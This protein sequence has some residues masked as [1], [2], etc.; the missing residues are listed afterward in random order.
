MTHIGYLHISGFKAIDQFEMEPKRM[1]LITGR[2]NMG[3]T[4]LLQSIDL[5][6]NPDNI[7]YLAKNLDKVINENNTTASIEGEFYKRQQTLTSYAS[8]IDHGN[9]HREI[10]LREPTEREVLELFSN[11]FNEII[12]LNEDYPV[13]FSGQVFESMSTADID[14]Y[15]ENIQNTLYES[16]NEISEERITSSMRDDIIVLEINGELYPYVHLGDN[17]NDLRGEIIDKSIAKIAEMHSI[18]PMENE[19]GKSTIYRELSQNF[20]RLLAPRFGGDRFVGKNPPMIKGVK[21]ISEPKTKPKSLN[22]NQENAA[23]RRSDI[24]DYLKENNIVNNLKDFS[25]NRLV[26]KDDDHKD[27][28]PYEFMG[29]GFKTIVSILWELFDQNNIGDVLLLEEPDIH[30]HPGYVEKLIRELI[31]ITIEKDIQLFI[32]THNRDMIEGFFSSS[33]ARTH[34]EYLVE[35]FQLI[36]LSENISKSLNY[37]QAKEEVEEVN[38]DLRGI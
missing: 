32:T 20:R 18:G 3:K 10:G 19:D 33:L 31:Q 17:F 22:L 26:F 24:E 35:N 29:A 4:S 23:V 28:V 38:S 21:L 34:G 36:Q 12:E 14:D 7:S 11:I 6:F 30:M 2:N 1:N 16:I 25:F 9:R 5:I 37:K 15:K 27:E 8:E 13:R